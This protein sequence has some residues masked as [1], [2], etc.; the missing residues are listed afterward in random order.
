MSND[1][2]DQRGRSARQVLVANK[3]TRRTAK[4]RKL[5]TRFCH[6]SKPAQTY[7]S[8]TLNKYTMVTKTKNAESATVGTELVKRRGL[9]GKLGFKKKSK[10]AA[11]A[12][13]AE[14]APEQ[15]VEEK[16][17]EKVEWSQRGDGA[18]RVRRPSRL[19]RR[20]SSASRPTFWNAGTSLQFTCDNG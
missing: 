18:I 3:P 4:T 14:P 20:L 19:A 12:P 5:P 13:V 8:P 7:I 16:V 2:T 1:T 17:E 15:P 10:K 11:K 6:K 9:L